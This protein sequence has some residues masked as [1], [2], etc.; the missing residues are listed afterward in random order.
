M[1]E[2]GLG[3]RRRSHLKAGVMPRTMVDTQVLAGSDTPSLSVW[4]PLLSSIP[5]SPTTDTNFWGDWYR[6]TRTG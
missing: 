2:E 1:Y 3:I 4:Y 6:E 5:P